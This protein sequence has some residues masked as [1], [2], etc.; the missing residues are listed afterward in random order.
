MII[1]DRYIN[2][3][4]IYEFTADFQRKLIALGLRWINLFSQGLERKRMFQPILWPITRLVEFIC[5]ILGVMLILIRALIYAVNL[6]ELQIHLYLDKDMAFKPRSSELFRDF[7]DFQKNFN[8]RLEVGFISTI[9][10]LDK[11]FRGQNVDSN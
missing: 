4:M 11:K 2:Q 1:R 9:Q 10:D 3:F 8:E 5:M 7:L 6:I